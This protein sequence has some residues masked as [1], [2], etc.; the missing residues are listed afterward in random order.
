MLFY[1]TVKHTASAGDMVNARTEK[2]HSVC[3]D[4]LISSNG[5]TSS[6]PS[7]GRVLCHA[8]FSNYYLGFS[9]KVPGGSGSFSKPA[10]TAG[11]LRG[12]PP[13]SRI[14]HFNPIFL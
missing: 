6:R 11:N 2:L 13:T 1:T 14:L 12:L 5:H 10:F 8:I 9:S 4:L 7:A 3:F